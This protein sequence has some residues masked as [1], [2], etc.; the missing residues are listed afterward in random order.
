MPFLK[1]R[2]RVSTTGL[3]AIAARR[4]VV[5]LAGLAQ[6]RAVLVASHDPIVLAAAG[7]VVTVARSADLEPAR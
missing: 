3:D 4:L 6:D 5:T 2:V 1:F 7:R